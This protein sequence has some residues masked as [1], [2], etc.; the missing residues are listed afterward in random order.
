MRDGLV[1]VEGKFVAAAV[2]NHGWSVPQADRLQVAGGTLPSVSCGGNVRDEAPRFCKDNDG[3]GSG[4]GVAAA[5]LIGGWS[6]NSHAGRER[7]A[8]AGDVQVPLRCRF[9]RY[10]AQRRAQVLSANT[11]LRPLRPRAPRTPKASGR[12]VWTTGSWLLFEYLEQASGG[13]AQDHGRSDC[14][15][16]TSR[17]TRCRSRGRRRCRARR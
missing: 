3:R 5:T 11:S 2:V 9:H 12:Y 14:A 8:R 1:G 17:G 16:A 13:R 4:H 10:A 6:A 15:P 7:E